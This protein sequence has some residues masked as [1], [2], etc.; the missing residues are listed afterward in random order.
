MEPVR[1][2]VAEWGNQGEWLWGPEL[3]G[4][5]K[6]T[7]DA[8]EALGAIPLQEL[9]SKREGHEESEAIGTPVT[10]KARL[11]HQWHKLDPVWREAFEAPLCKAVQVYLNHQAVEGV[12][13]GRVIPGERIL[14]SRFVLTNKGE[15]DLENA[16]L[17]GRWIFG[18]HRDPDI[19]AWETISPTVALLGHN[20]IIVLANALGWKMQLADVSAAFLQGKDLPA[21]RNIYV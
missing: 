9:D 5:L 11:E 6:E 21:E 3:S 4:L 20:L 14:T 12:P 10:G 18:G 2:S 7:H 1:K 16:D 19:G 13:K 15:A 8:H 17:K